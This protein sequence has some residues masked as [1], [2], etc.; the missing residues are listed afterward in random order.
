MIVVEPQTAV[1]NITTGASSYRNIFPQTNSYRALVAFLRYGTG[2]EQFPLRMKKLFQKQMA[3]SKNGGGKFSQRKVGC[4]KEKR[5]V[6]E[7]MLFSQRKKSNRWE[8]MLSQ[9]KI[10][11]SQGMWFSQRNEGLLREKMIFSKKRLFP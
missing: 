2:M 8:K 1:P 10:V 7:R 5:A 11:L 9:K 6:S 3:F 4:L